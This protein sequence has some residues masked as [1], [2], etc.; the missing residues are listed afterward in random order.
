MVPSSGPEPPIVRSAGEVGSIR[1]NLPNNSSRSVEIGRQAR[2]R[3]VWVK[4][5]GF[6]SHLRHQK[7]GFIRFV[8]FLKFIM[9]IIPLYEPYSFINFIAKVGGIA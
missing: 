4:P 6:N 5:C 3:S 9:L 7:N 1:Y 8:M 2:L